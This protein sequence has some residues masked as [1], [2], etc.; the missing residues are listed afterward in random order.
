[1]RDYIL[2]RLLIMLPIM[3]GVSFLTFVA[4]NLIA[5]D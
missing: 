3:F 2:R 5:G 1:M 4:F